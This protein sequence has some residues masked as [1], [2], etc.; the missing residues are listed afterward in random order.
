VFSVVPAV[1]PCV[2]G[3]RRVLNSSLLICCFF[4]YNFMFNYYLDYSML[5]VVFMSCNRRHKN[6]NGNKDTE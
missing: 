6:Q 3:V 2:G 4:M 1:L 5:Q